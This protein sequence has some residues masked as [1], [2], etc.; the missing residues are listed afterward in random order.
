MGLKI[1]L[2]IFSM[3]IV[4][5]SH[6]EGREETEMIVYRELPSLITDLG[7]SA[8]TLYSVSNSISRH[9]RQISIPKSDG[10]CRELS[11]PDRLLKSIQKKINEKLLCLE[12]I[13]P[14]AMAY[15]P[16]GST[17]LN[18]AQHVRK[19]ILLKLDINKFFDHITYALVKER[20]FPADRYSEGN[21]VLLA[22]LCTYK[23]VLP[24]GAPTSPAISN[25]ILFSFDTAVGAYCERRGIAY[26][27]YCDDMTFSGDFEPDKL[28]V[29]VR[30]ELKK[31]GFYLNDRKTKILRSGKR[32]IVTG[33]VVNE[34]V[35]VPKEYIRNLIQE[36]YYCKKYGLRAHME[37]KGITVPPEKYASQLFGRISYVL[38][39]DTGNKTLLEYRERLIEEISGKHS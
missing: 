10:G 8:K 3:R 2:R 30:D 34:K 23:G 12:N 24:Q 21:R 36:L 9:Y 38:S 31:L 13:S 32:L 22:L 14:Y 19:K 6:S 20:A 16:G 18:A 4:L 15:R 5:F 37:R 1:Q 33:L 7:F 35:R 29:V 25:I 39:T 26:T 27:R 11:V 17:R 28:I